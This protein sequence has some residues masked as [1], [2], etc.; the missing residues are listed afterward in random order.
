MGA[1]QA[2]APEDLGIPRAEPIEDPYVNLD[3]QMWDTDMGN[4]Y[5]DIQG[6]ASTSGARGH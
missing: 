5:L 4:P 1:P 3:E 2:E 6:S